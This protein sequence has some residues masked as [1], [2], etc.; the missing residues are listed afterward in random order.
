MRNNELGWDDFI[1]A[2]DPV[3]EFCVH[4]EDPR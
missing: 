3:S 4:V 2:A 1:S